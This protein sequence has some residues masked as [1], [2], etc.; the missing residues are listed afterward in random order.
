MADH[1]VLQ[2]V[3]EAT[4]AQIAHSVS[5]V[6]QQQDVEAGTTVAASSVTQL[7]EARPTT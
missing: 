5:A 7:A 2:C 4:I 1:S 3:T 6:E